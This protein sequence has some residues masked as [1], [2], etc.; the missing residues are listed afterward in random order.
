MF[1]IYFCQVLHGSILPK[2]DRPVAFLWLNFS[3][4]F[5]FQLLFFY[6]TGFFGLCSC[7]WFSLTDASS[8]SLWIC[9]ILRIHCTAGEEW[10]LF[11]VVASVNDGIANLPTNLLG[12]CPR[13]SPWTVFLNFS[14]LTPKE[15]FIHGFP[16]HLNENLIQVYQMWLFARP[17]TI[18]I[19]KILH[20]LAKLL[21]LVWIHALGGRC[22]GMASLG[23]RYA[24][25]FPKALLPLR[26]SDSVY[27]CSHHSEDW[28]CQTLLTGSWVWDGILLRF[29]FTV[30][31]H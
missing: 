28:H 20:P 13:V 8:Y 15:P 10:V 5:S 9:Q 31:N 16:N 12:T 19:P 23:C 22:P 24:R 14:L 25:L 1:S 29:E 3:L 26:T 4:F 7:D 11:Y 2:W 6:P 30:S 27:E 21:P 18:V 17:Q